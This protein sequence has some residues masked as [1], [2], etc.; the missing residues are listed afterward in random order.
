MTSA[1]DIGHGAGSRFM[2]AGKTMTVYMQMPGTRTANVLATTEH[3][4]GILMSSIL[5]G[6]VV[7][8]G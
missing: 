8:K 4:L 3:F 7:T 6:V 1:V 2:S 5:L